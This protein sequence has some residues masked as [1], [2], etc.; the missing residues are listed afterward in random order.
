MEYSKERY[1]A[2]ITSLFERHPSVQKVGFAAGAYK[3][4][5]E[6]MQRFG[7]ALGEP[8]KKFSTIHIAG[9][10]GKGS[11]SS[12]LAAALAATG[13][14]VGLYT[15]PHLVDFRERMKI[16]SGGSWA[17]VSEKYVW[18]FLHSAPLDDLSFF[19]I[20]TGMAFSWFA[21]QEVDV[22]VIETGLGGRLDS[23]NI[24]TPELSIITSIGL[25]HC[26]M[27]G[28]TR[29]KIAAEK[30]GIFKSGVPALVANRDDETAP[31]FEVKAAEVH[32]PLFFAD[33][34]AEPDFRL[35]LEGPYQQANLHTVL[36]AL[37]LLGV[38]P[39]TEAL[40][41]SG[42]ITGFRGRWE[43]LCD[44]PE[45]ICDIGHN[46]DALRINFARLAESGRPLYIVY[47]IMADKDLNAIRP[48]MPADARYY[49]VAP[50]ISR[51]L[52]VDELYARTEGLVRERYGSVAEGVKAAMQDAAKVPDSLVYIGGSNFVVSECISY[53]EKDF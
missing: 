26:A 13:L 19:E 49:L 23:T 43:R 27:L 22:A 10:N 21:S 50:A 35:D 17:M 2:L 28:D 30:A 7:R 42:R 32:C 38:E 48:L 51:S 40:K 11:V 36:A 34:F 8:W 25:D 24:I 3:P 46:P 5:L 33:D 52:P 39:D 20:T 31:V 15:S 18:D 4:G 29:A 44:K 45:T 47:G 1:N 6:G 16:V 12:M 53:L 9:T 41:H 37:E 14:R